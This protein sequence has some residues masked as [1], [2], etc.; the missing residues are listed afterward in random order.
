MGEINCRGGSVGTDIGH[1]INK[2]LLDPREGRSKRR[3]TGPQESLRKRDV[4]GPYKTN[5]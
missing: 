1:K 5:T 2:N 3:G 4:G